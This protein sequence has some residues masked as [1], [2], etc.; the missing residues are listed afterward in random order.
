MFLCIQTPFSV[1][2][3]IFVLICIEHVYAYIDMYSFLLCQY[4][5]NTSMYYL[6]HMY[7]MYCIYYYVFVCIARIACIVCITCM[8][9]YLYVFGRISCILCIACIAMYWY[10]LIV[11]LVWWLYCLYGAYK[12]VFACICLY[13]LVSIC[14]V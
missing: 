1:L 12:L 4:W 8:Y 9:L 2:A 3:C 5:W 10:V 7:C 6:Y 14:I 11:L 13:L